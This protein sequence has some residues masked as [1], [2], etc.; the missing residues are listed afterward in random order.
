LMC[1]QH[2]PIQQQERVNPNRACSACRL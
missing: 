1:N 2:K